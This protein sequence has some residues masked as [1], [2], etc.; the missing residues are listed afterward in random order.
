MLA[1]RIRGVE[2]RY[3]LASITVVP[4]AKGDASPAVAGSWR[5]TA[6]PP[7]FPSWLAQ[8][9]R[10]IVI[11]GTSGHRAVVARA[12]EVID[13]A[14]QA[15]AVVAD[16]PL[17]DDVVARMQASSNIELIDAGATTAVG[18][19]AAGDGV[20]AV[21]DEGVSLGPGGQPVT[22]TGG[23][24]WVGYFDLLDWST[25]EQGRGTVNFRFFPTTFYDQVARGG[26]FSLARI[27]LLLMMAIGG[28]FLT[29]EA[30]ALVMGFALARS[31]TGAVH[32][33]FTGT[34]R[35]RGGTG[36]IGYRWRP[37]TS[38]VSWPGRSMR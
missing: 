35:V 14:G 31:I 22:A 7:G 29:I 15:V 4:R 38:W 34:E 12:A 5:H 37:G 32:E 3:P 20:P 33:L 30:V 1:R 28:M 8:N 16:L 10:G 19:P 23:F 36:P 24:Q 18:G 26:D 6:E 21:D 17:A 27:F 11:T 9:G 2:G 13:V 25:G